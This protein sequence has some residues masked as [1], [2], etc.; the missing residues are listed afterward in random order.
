MCQNAI[1]WAYSWATRKHCI[2]KIF[3]CTFTPWPCNASGSLWECNCPRIYNFW[4]HTAVHVI[5]SCSASFWLLCFL[6]IFNGIPKA[7]WN[8]KKWIKKKR[9]ETETKNER[10]TWTVGNSK[11]GTN[12]LHSGYKHRTTWIFSML[13]GGAG[14]FCQMIRGVGGGWYWTIFARTYFISKIQK[15]IQISII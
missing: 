15:V 7:G 6:F 14:V 12:R 1:K 11:S 3:F 13:G 9:R 8:A 4:V 10:I 2:P 5:I